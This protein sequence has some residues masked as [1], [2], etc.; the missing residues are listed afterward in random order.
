MAKRKYTQ[1]VL[2]G[3]EVPD[4]TLK[5]V[6]ATKNSEENQPEIQPNQRIVFKSKTRKKKG[7]FIPNTQ[8]VLMCLFLDRKWHWST[9]VRPVACTECPNVRNYVLC[10]NTQPERF[11]SEACLIHT[12]R[13]LEPIIDRFIDGTASSDEV[14]SIMD[15]FFKAGRPEAK[16]ITID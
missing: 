1:L 8:I 6:S 15:A 10:H 2:Q 11:C 13:R 3:K 7:Q 14:K 9:F 16:L 12:A 4:S 5:I